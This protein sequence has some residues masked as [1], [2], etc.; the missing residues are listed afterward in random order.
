MFRK[1]SPTTSD[2]LNNCRW[3]ESKRRQKEKRRNDLIN[4]QEGFDSITGAP[5]EGEDRQDLTIHHFIRKRGRGAGG[6]EDKTNQALLTH[7][8]HALE[9][10]LAAFGAADAETFH[11]EISG[12]YGQ[13]EAMRDDDELSELSALIE[14]RTGRKIKFY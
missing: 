6:R 10:V 4:I 3:G 9:H 7:V 5:I 12:A 1:E 8:G 13:I 14:E 11:Q 2:R